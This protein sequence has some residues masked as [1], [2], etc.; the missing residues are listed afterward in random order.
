MRPQAVVET[1]SPRNGV[2]RLFGGTHSRCAAAAI[3]PAG[4][5]G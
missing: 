4:R 3:G 1:P 2:P 5:C